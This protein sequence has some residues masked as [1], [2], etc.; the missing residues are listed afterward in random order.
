MKSDMIVGIAQL[1]VLIAGGLIAFY[2]GQDAMGSILIGAAAGSAK[3]QNFV[4]WLPKIKSA[5]SEVVK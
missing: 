2:M 5:P 3:P 1:T 4:P